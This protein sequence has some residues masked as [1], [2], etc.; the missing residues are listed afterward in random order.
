MGRAQRFKQES[1]QDSLTD[2]IDR[3]CRQAQTFKY[4]PAYCFNCGHWY[5]WG[6]CVCVLSRY[7][8]TLLNPFSTI[9]KPGHQQTPTASMVYIS[10]STT[11]QC[12]DPHS[13]CSWT[14]GLANKLPQRMEAGG[15]LSRWL[16]CRVIAWERLKQ[17][18]DRN[19]SH[20]V[21]GGVKFPGV[22]NSDW[23]SPEWRLVVW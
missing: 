5:I 8:Q 13:I 20:P 16:I 9:P 10:A 21:G 4:A 3:R 12:P 17:P 1:S 18:K 2:W 23:L 14:A 19:I 22:I 11:E 6:V 7:T 15:R